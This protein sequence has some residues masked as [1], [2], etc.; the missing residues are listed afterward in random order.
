MASQI[1]AKLIELAYNVVQ[2]DLADHEIEDRLIGELV[3]K[4]LDFTTEQGEEGTILFHSI[5]QGKHQPSTVVCLQAKGVEFQQ[6]P[7]RLSHDM[8]YIFYKAF[9]EE[10]LHNGT[11]FLITTPAVQTLGPSNILIEFVMFGNTIHQINRCLAIFAEVIRKHQS[12][13]HQTAIDMYDQAG[14]EWDDSPDISLEDP[15]DNS[16]TQETPMEYLSTISS[17]EVYIEEYI[18]YIDGEDKEFREMID[19]RNTFAESEFK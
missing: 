9:G 11:K 6:E 10:F 18:K 19:N 14:N 7:G 3:G 4:S 8:S 2:S 12:E 15:I 17:E 16:I 1:I 5:G 13:L